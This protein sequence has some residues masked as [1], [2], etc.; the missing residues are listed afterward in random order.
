MFKKILI[1]NRG[2]IAVRIIQACQEMHIR[3]VAVYSEA[4]RLSLH[5]Q[6]VDESVDIGK[7]SPLESYL[8][9]EK[10]IAAARKSG[11]EAIHPGYGF[12]SENRD[13]AQACQDAGIVF[14]GPAPDAIR[15]M[16]DKRKAK[17]IMEGAGVPVVPGYYG[18]DQSVQ[19][20]RVESEKIGFPVMV[21]AAA[22]GGGKGMRVVQNIG[23]LESA[24]QGA[25]REAL[26]AFGNDDLFLEKYIENPRHIEFQILADSYGNT[27]HLFE[28]E[29][30]IQRRHQKIVEETPSVALTPELR[31]EMGK[32]AVTAAQAVDYVNAGTIEFIFDTRDKSYYFLEMNTRLQVEHSVTEL[33]T[34]VDLAQEQIRIAAG[35]KLNR[36]QDQ[37]NQYGHSI[38]TRI[39][40]EDPNAGF[41]PQTGVI[42]T[43]EMPQGPHIRH[44][45]GIYAGGEVSVYYDPLL[46][47]LTVFAESR[48]KAIERMS[49]ALRGYVI[50][51]V[52]HNIDFLID[53]IE[54]PEFAAGATTT[55][56]IEE[57]LG[58]PKERSLELPKEALM[59]AAIAETILERNVGSHPATASVEGDLYS[60]WRS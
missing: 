35:E 41:L 21:K 34:G 7:S 42:Q 4:D 29:C 37:V 13:F 1:A 60:P 3:A 24:V 50:L 6:Q 14:I 33:T 22:G 32:I 30:S 20:F 31:R 54:H 12:L 28:R 27:I 58:D 43:L 53:V 11:A 18:D 38:E 19:R 40:A 47:K 8:C 56:F 39:Y 51:G 15:R 9:I 46:A 26:S 55:H 5:V 48:V 59:A 17:A 44:D 23:D 2:E 57:C 45:T 52:R 49:R 36:S 10:I 25:R 16:G